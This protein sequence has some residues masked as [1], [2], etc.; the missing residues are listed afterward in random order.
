MPACVQLSQEVASSVTLNLHGL[1]G[2]HKD[3]LSTI[4]RGN[5][6]SFLSILD[7]VLKWHHMGILSLST[8]TGHWGQVT[9]RVKNLPRA[10]PVA[11]QLKVDFGLVPLIQLF[12]RHSFPPRNS[13]MTVKKSQNP[14]YFFRRSRKETRPIW[15][16]QCHQM[17]GQWFYLAQ[18]S[19]FFRVV[20]IGHLSKWRAAT[21]LWSISAILEVTVVAIVKVVA[22]TNRMVNSHWYIPFER[23]KV[24][25]YKDL[26]EF[27]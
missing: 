2:R 20:P 11:L 19:L 21:V 16:P 1:H 25:L 10:F 23:G 4:A 3:S 6:F 26:D 8:C 14:T 7:C 12:E 9:R 17:S 15:R 27:I 13:R 5:W 24:S 22:P 18:S